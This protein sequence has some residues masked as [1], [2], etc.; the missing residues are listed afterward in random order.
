MHLTD[1]D[2]SHRFKS[3][4]ERVYEVMKGG[5]TQVAVTNGALAMK[6]QQLAEYSDHAMEKVI[7]KNAE[8]KANE[9]HRMNDGKGMSQQ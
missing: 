5:M 4:R 1:T 7:Q 8:G 3:V 6:T 9:F 2:F